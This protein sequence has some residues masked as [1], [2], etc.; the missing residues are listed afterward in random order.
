MPSFLDKSGVP[1]QLAAL[2]VMNEYLHH[3]D[4]FASGQLATPEVVTTP[5]S[6]QPLPDR[7]ADRGGHHLQPLQNPSADPVHPIGYHA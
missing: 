4:R 7:L 5:G 6:Q 3:I 2:P 1:L